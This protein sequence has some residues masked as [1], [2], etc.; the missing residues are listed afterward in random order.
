L[1]PSRDTTAG[2]V[3]LDL[4]KLARADGRT[5]QELFQFYVLEAFLDRLARSDQADRFVLKG[6][7]LLAAFGERRPTRDID[8]QALAL[9]NDADIV[10]A[11]MVE[12]GGVDVDDG[13]VFD[14]GSAT[15]EVIRGDDVYAGVRVSMAATLLP[16]ELNF[17]VDMNVG[18]PIIPAPEQIRLPRLLGGEITVRGYPLSMVYA[19]KIVTALARGT[20]NTRWRDFVDLYLLPR[21]HRVHGT[22]LQA[23]V[24]AVAARR[25]VELVPLREV[26]DGYGAIG[27]SRWAPWRRKQSLADRVPEDFSDVIEAVVLFA[28]AVIGGTAVGL[29]WEPASRRWQ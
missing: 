10:K 13:V 11:H 12:I 24:G 3:Y 19:E 27:Q 16:A 23:S 21:R 17:H 15:A 7:V 6:G 2:R 14:A 25:G 4:Q 9:G 8:L 29:H 26:L 18:D 28:D 5:G 22:E 20:A 1:T